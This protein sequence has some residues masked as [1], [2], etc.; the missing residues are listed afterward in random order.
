MLIRTR[1]RNKGDGILPFFVA[2]LQ[3]IDDTKNLIDSTSNAKRIAKYKPNFL[4]RV[5]D[6]DV[7]D[8]GR[9]FARIDYILLNPSIIIRKVSV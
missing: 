2:F 8:T 4:V 3:S 6:E 1:H 7:S 9:N 5:N